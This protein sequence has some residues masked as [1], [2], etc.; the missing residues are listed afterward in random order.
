MT[1]S[2]D[3]N[4][5]T[6]WKA[7][8]FRSIDLPMPQP[9]N[10]T[11]GV[12]RSAVVM[13]GSMQWNMAM[14]DWFFHTLLTALTCSAIFSTNGTM[15]R[16]IKFSEIDPECTIGW[17]SRTSKKAST[18]TQLS[19]TVMRIRH[20]ANVSLSAV[21]SSS[22]FSRIWSSK[23]L[24]LLVLWNMWTKN[25]LNKMIAV[26]LLKLSVSSESRANE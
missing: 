25:M 10:T 15:I 11:I 8:K 19:D 5:E 4:N 2:I 1:T 26:P 6:T 3:S 7:S 16:P 18:Q 21:S 22:S 14:F 9:T 23:V 24:R 12:F 13:D 20:S 17:I